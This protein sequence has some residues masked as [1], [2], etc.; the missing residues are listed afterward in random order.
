MNLFSIKLFNRYKVLEIAI[1]IYDINKF[2][3]Q[4]FNAF[5]ILLFENSNND[6]KFFIVNFIIKLSWKHDFKYINYE[7]K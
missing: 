1:I 5:R 3:H 4:N 6:Q 2:F 7:V